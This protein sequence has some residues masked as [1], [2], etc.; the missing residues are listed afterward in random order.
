MNF[1]FRV[2]ISLLLMFGLW[3]CLNVETTV[4]VGADGSGILESRVLMNQQASQLMQG[5]T[6]GGSR[7]PDLLD[8]E[9]L[10]RNAEKMGI[11]VRFIS[12]ERIISQ[13]GNGYRALYAFDDIN[14]LKIHENPEEPTVS[15]PGTKENPFS[16]KISFSFQKGR[17]SIL[18]IRIPKPQE[19]PN[20][21]NSQTDSEKPNVDAEQQDITKESVEVFKSLFRGLRM[22]FAVE[23][24]GSVLATNATHQEGSRITLMEMDF[25]QLTSNADLFRNIVKAG[26]KN[27]E[28]LT[29]MLRTFPGIKAEPQETVT[30][31]F[32]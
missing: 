3:G 30:V 9:K 11:G 23:V 19:K 27:P 16:E 21:P 28:E 1:R 14:N 6:K 4:R 17:P 12:A 10:R 18:T 13:Q 7:P 2:L 20:A 29:E 24:E 8:E 32:R 31:E 26:R 5:G 22:V 25:D 15:D